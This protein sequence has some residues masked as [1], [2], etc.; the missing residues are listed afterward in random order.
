MSPCFVAGVVVSPVSYPVSL[1]PFFAGD[2]DDCIVTPTVQGQ[3]TPL[4][5]ALCD[6][7]MDLTAEGQSATIEHVRGKLGARF[8]HMTTPATEVIYD[9]LAQLMQEQKI[10]QTSKG[11]FIFTP[12]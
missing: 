9:T 10:Y 11:Y 1:N 6:V 8:P 12:E 3:F 5:E 7:I 2:I 4:P